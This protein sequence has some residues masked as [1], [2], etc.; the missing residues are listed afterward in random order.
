MISIESVSG[1]QEVISKSGVREIEVDITYQINDY[2]LTRTA[3]V[4]LLDGL[5]SLG[6]MEF[7]AKKLKEDGYDISI[8]EFKKN[9]IDVISKKVLFT[10][11]IA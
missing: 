4:S 10:K 7:I 9:V 6:G 2:Y 1:I 5:L 3:R 8:D 11:L